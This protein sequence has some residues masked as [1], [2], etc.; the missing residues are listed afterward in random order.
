MLTN[1]K[2]GTYTYPTQGTTSIR[3]HAPLTIAGQAVSYDANG[4]T[5]AYTLS[6][7]TKTFTYDGENRPLSVALSGGATTTFVYGPDG[8][9]TRKTT[10]TDVSWYLGGDL[11]LAVSSSI[12]AGE[13]AQ[14][15]HAD[16]QRRN[17]TLSYLHK[18]HLATNRINTTSAG[19][20][21]QRILYTPYG[22]PS[23]SPLHSK[24]YINER[25][26]TETGL[27][28][29]HA[30][31]YDPALGRFLS[32]D[33]WDPILSGV[34]INRY[35]YALNDPIN[36]SDAGGHAI[37]DN[38]RP[39]AEE[40]AN[41]ELNDR[42]RAEYAEDRAHDLV[43]ASEEYVSKQAALH[44]VQFK[45]AFRNPA[46]IYDPKRDAINT[47]DEVFGIFVGGPV[48]SMGK[49]VVAKSLA[50]SLERTAEKTI[51]RETVEG[52]EKTSLKITEKY[53]R[54]KNATTK[55]QREA[56]QGKPCVEC[57]QVTPKQFAN[58][59]E[60]L[61]KEYYRTGKID[62]ANMRKLDAVNTHCPTCS[63]RQGATLSRYSKEMAREYGLE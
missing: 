23:V 55:A 42:A 7:Q 4:N 41:R 44:G 33:T 17:T 32:P 8:E 61:V 57:G 62:Q 52:L 60:A 30:R 24:A 11:E 3:P 2:V 6:G 49:Y 21:V 27:S 5:L 28:Y 22:K 18:D 48:A 38:A 29:L 26:D 16:V 31:Y 63:A 14:Y 45:D 13:W 34:D 54:P 10:G 56:V 43:L 40:R 9:R 12:P 15:L 25:Y 20:L 46:F 36:G 58:H 51:A 47:A 19:A 1:S 39:D 53:A 50:R 35:A 59:K 37:A